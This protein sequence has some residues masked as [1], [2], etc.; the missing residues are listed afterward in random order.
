[1]R[2]HIVPHSA[3]G[4]RCGAAMTTCLLLADNTAPA[5][6][7]LRLLHRR[8]QVGLQGG[9]RLHRPLSQ[10][11]GR[12]LEGG[13]A[14]ERTGYTS[15]QSVRP[16]SLLS[17]LTTYKEGHPRITTLRTLFGLVCG[18][19]GR[20]VAMLGLVSYKHSVCTHGVMH[21]YLYVD[22]ALYLWVGVR[23]RCMNRRPVPHKY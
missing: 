20:L 22:N 11:T 21:M 12:Q 6:P 10:R 13:A 19:L 18:K 2:Y 9:V 16:S 17:P 14:G 15:H 1:M 23:L 5:S 8:R 3:R 7:H 4:C